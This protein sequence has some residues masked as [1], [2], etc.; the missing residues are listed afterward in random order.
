MNTAKSQILANDKKQGYVDL[1]IGG[2]PIYYQYDDI[3]N[4]I[5]TT[6]FYYE[7]ENRDIH[8]LPKLKS[9]DILRIA[10]LRASNPK[11]EMDLDFSKIWGV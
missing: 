3:V 5:H 8:A 6:Y 11:F 2:I 10:N 1:Y 4:L 9:T 7:R